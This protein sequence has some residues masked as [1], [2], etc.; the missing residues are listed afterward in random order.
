MSAVV[1]LQHE[2]PLPRNAEARPEA[3]VP[4]ESMAPASFALLDEGVIAC[5]VAEAARTGRSVVA[6][7]TETTGRSPLDL[8][9]AVAAALDYRFVGSD[10]LSMLEPAFDILPPSEATRR[11]CAVV[12]TPGGLLAMVADPFDAALRSWLE[13]RTPEVLEWAVAAGHELANFIARRAEALRAIDA[14][15]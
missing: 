6:I 1:P 7:L 3:A 10:E 5:A 2:E 15:L 13:T 12:R 8:A 9:Q 14:V 11:C 4:A